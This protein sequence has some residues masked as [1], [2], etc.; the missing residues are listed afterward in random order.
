MLV[1]EVEFIDHRFHDAFC[2]I[3]IINGKA[4]RVSEPLGL[5][6]ENPGEDGVEGA[7]IQVSGFVVAENVFDP[8]LHFPGRLIGECQGEDPE[9][10]HPV[11]HEVSD[12]GGEHLGFAASGAGNDHQGSFHMEDGFPLSVVQTLQVFLHNCKLG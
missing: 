1:V 5:A 6:S 7:Y 2:V 10:V 12:A 8:F 11:G 9:G 3:G 4:L